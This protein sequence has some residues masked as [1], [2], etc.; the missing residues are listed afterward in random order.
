M[1]LN[2]KQKFWDQKPYWCQPWSIITFGILVL[3]FSWTF[4]NNFII[5]TILGF[6]VIVWWALFLIIAPSSYDETTNK[7]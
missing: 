7:K 5:T 1:D 6:M 4:F 2:S 3:I